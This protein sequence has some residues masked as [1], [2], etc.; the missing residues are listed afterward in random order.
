MVKKKNVPKF[1]RHEYYKHKRLEDVWRRP[2]GIHSKQR[3]GER[4]KGPVV[5]VGYRQ[6]KSVRGLTKSGLRPVRI[7]SLNELEKLDSKKEIAVLSAGLGRKKKTEIVF[8]AMEKGIKIQ[9]VKRLF[10]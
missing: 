8:R 1:K 9:N 5:K 4:D 6:P 3:V 2:T 7:N 10:R